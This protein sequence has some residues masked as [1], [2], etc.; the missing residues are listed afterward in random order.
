[1]AIIRHAILYH[2][3]Q[4]IT[5]EEND[6]DQNKKKKNMQL[7]NIVNLVLYEKCIQLQS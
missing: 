6:C 4:I 3:E 2:S 5:D 7:L 1:M